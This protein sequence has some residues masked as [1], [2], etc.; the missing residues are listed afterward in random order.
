MINLPTYIYSEESRTYLR[1]KHKLEQQLTNKFGTTYLWHRAPFADLDHPIEVCCKSH[2][3]FPTT[4]K[5]LLSPKFKGCPKCLHYRLN[6]AGGHLHLGIKYSRSRFIAEATA[7]NGHIFDFS[8]VKF[9]GFNQPVSVPCRTHGT[10]RY[11]KP[12]RF[13]SPTA[14]NKCSAEAPR[15][16]TSAFVSK[17][18][19][20]HSNRYDYSPSIY[21][22]TSTPLDI[23]CPLHGKFS[24][25]PH[26]H[27]TNGLGCPKCRVT[28]FNSSKPGSFYY[29]S[30]NNGQAF[31]IGITNSSFT[32]CYSSA[33]L[34]HISIL[35]S[36]DYP[37]GYS[38]RDRATRLLKE[39]EHLKYLGPPLLSTGNN[40]VFTEDILNIT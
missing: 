10:K 20:V 31:A 11:R 2:G 7:V 29:L 22:D 1:Q 4:F 40:G 23:I 33:D 37:H 8:R 5:K 38:A 9:H 32:R 25:T 14:C 15:F 30:I 21:R 36:E 35:F 26:D 18:Q 3:F 27:F 34:E 6:F 19:L 16:S 17:A 24:R 12:A 39:F 13:L 28:S